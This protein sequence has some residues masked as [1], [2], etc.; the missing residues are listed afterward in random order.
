MNLSL[1]LHQCPACL[2]RPPWR[3]FVKGGRRPYSCCFVGCCLQTCSIL[4]TAFLCSCRQA[5]SP[6][7]YV[8]HL[9]SSVDTIA[10]WKKMHFILSVRSDFQSILVQKWRDKWR[11][12]LCQLLNNWW[13]A[14]KLISLKAIILVSVIGHLCYQRLMMTFFYDSWNL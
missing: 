1:L 7:V 8:V 2:V 6:A 14:L 3:V 4:L 10:V 9:Y 11:L 5:F 13:E 12:F